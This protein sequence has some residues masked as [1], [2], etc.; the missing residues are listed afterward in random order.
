MDFSGSDAIESALSLLAVTLEARGESPYD[1]VVIGGAAINLAGFAIRPTRDVDVLGLLDRREPGETAMLAKRK[2]LPEPVVS[3][4]R[5]V[6]EALGLDPNWLNAGPADLLDW[7]MPD[8]FAQRLIIRR[9]GPKL[10]IHTPAREDL[11]CLK[12]YAAADTGVGRHTEDLNAMRPAC[13]ELLDG[14]RWAAT[15]D[16]SDGFR[17][18]LV[19]LLR[20]YGCDQAAEVFSDES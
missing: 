2:P 16:P 19:Q 11:I 8:G 18:M 10:A 14:A 3:A 5:A 6:A 13:D 20:Y 15:Q 12:V 4:A 17:G 9:F 1:L 7:G